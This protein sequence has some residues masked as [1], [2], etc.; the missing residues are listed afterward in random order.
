LDT[1][2]LIPNS[3]FFI[4]LMLR[5]K[6]KGHQKVSRGEKTIGRPY[7]SHKKVNIVSMSLSSREVFNDGDVSQF[8]C[9]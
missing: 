8:T 4:H 3:I 7:S 2:V 5:N 9:Y 6:R 1:H